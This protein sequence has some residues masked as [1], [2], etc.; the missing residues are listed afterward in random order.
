MQI[1]KGRR[2]GLKLYLPSYV[3]DE[4]TIY[5]DIKN[6]IGKHTTH[7]TIVTRCFIAQKIDQSDLGEAAKG[8]LTI[9]T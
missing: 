8:K 5:R 6:A 3:E 2:F 9:H 1:E 7:F 4:N